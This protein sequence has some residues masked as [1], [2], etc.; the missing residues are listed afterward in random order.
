LPLA[1]NSLLSGERRQKRK[2]ECK[3]AQLKSS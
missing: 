3:R 1:S 2:A